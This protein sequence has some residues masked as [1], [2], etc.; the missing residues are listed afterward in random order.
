[1]LQLPSNP[2][3]DN[4][5]VYHPQLVVSV[6]SI[7]VM[8]AKLALMPN[9][10]HDHHDRGLYHDW[11]IVCMDFR[12]DDQPKQDVDHFYDQQIDFLLN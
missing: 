3:Q 1:M 11:M 6:D 7:V 4:S 5:T 2:T 8:L 12:Y 9:L 10:D